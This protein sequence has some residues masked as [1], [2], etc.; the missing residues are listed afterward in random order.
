M[1]YDIKNFPFLQE[2]IKETELITEEFKKQQTNP[3]LGDFILNDY[4]K[5]CSHIDY[6]AIEQEI[7]PNNLGFDFR[8]ESWGAFPLYK[9]GFEIKWYSVNETF[10]IALKNILKVPNSY[11]SAFVKL[12]SKKGIKDHKHFQRH[13]VFHLCLV[14]LDGYSE[15]YCGNEKRILKNQGDWVIFD[16]SVSHS[17][18]NFSNT[19]RVNFVIDF[20]FDFS[21][22]G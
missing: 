20:P 4:P 14:D 15:I 10:P 6:Y 5:G 13:L 12:A 21:Q 11:F 1:F 3:L 18:F 9:N 16:S 7:A 8:N 19:N 2:I 17:S 22:L